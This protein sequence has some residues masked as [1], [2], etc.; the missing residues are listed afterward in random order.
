M[1]KCD[2]NKLLCNF[3]EITLRHGCSPV[4]LLHIFRTLHFQC[5][6]LLFSRYCCSRVG[7]YYH[8]PSGLHGAERLIVKYCTPAQQMKGKRKT[9]GV[10]SFNTSGGDVATIQKYLNSINIT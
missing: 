4:N 10:N 8:P 3:I 7:W 2:F 9:S 5:L 1:P 6:L